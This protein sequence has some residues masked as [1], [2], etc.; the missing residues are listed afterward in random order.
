MYEGHMVFSFL[1]YIW[2]CPLMVGL[3]LSRTQTRP[4]SFLIDRVLGLVGAHR[5][6]QIV[7]LYSTCL[8]ISLFVIGLHQLKFVCMFHQTT[9]VHSTKQQKGQ[10]MTFKLQCQLCQSRLITLFVMMFT[11]NVGETWGWN[12][13]GDGLFMWKHQQPQN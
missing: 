5:A 4:D 11:C 9:K 3:D 12:C 2:L 1:L 6:R 7:C 13:V 10:V 8:M